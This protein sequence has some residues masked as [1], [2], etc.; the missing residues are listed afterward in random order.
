MPGPSCPVPL[1]EPST[2]GLAVVAA[3]TKVAVGAAVGV[4][5]GKGERVGVAGT[6]GSAVGALT[7][8]GIA[9]SV[10]TARNLKR[11]SPPM[12][13]N[14]RKSDAVS[15]RAITINSLLL[16][17]PVP[18]SILSLHLLIRIV[19]RLPPP[20]ERTTW[21]R[22]C[23]CL[24]IV[25]RPSYRLKSRSSSSTTSGSI[26]FVTSRVSAW[27][28]SSKPSCD[29]FSLKVKTKISWFTST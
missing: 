3:T 23:Y 27:A 8:G 13:S 5:L 26:Q 1:F 6:S 11:T 24:S 22:R 20:S 2:G 16:L 7:S 17:I 9:T 19:C 18:L 21:T 4:A 12:P 15:T 10:G 29:P 25:K 28:G 14:P